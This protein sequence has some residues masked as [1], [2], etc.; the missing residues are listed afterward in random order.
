MTHSEDENY[1]YGVL[2]FTSSVIMINYF[3]LDS[4]FFRRKFCGMLSFATSFNFIIHFFGSLLLKQ[5]F[6]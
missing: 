2:K 6:Y 5:K 3:D 1:I 4:F